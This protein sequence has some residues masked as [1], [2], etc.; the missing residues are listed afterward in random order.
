MSRIFWRWA[1]LWVIDDVGF[2]L[3]GLG[4]TIRAALA[5]IIPVVHAFYAGPIFMRLLVLDGTYSHAVCGFSLVSSWAGQSATRGA[6]SLWPLLLFLL[7]PGAPHPRPQPLF[8]AFAIALRV[9]W[10]FKLM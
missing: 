1:R 3:H 4:I 5:R 9:A 8:G 10:I 6:P 2:A 7:R